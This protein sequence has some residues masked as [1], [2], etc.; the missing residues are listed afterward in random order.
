MRHLVY[1]IKYVFNEHVIDSASSI[2]FE[3]SITS[4][5]IYYNYWRILLDFQ[6]LAHQLPPCS[7][8]LFVFLISFFL[9]NSLSRLWQGILLW[10]LKIIVEFLLGSWHCVINC[11]LL[12]LK[13]LHFLA[14]L[15]QCILY[16]TPWGLFE[17]NI[18]Y[19]R[20]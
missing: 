9:Y 10:T 12:L 18:M 3:N 2:R 11:T 7:D 8:R 17:V 5:I 14:I 19:I 13:R 4:L 20:S 6:Y 15:Y 1:S 16:R